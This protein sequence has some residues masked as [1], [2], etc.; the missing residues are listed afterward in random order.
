MQLSINE[1]LSLSRFNDSFSSYMHKFLF[2]GMNYVYEVC[3]STILSYEKINLGLL[4]YRPKSIIC[5]VFGF[6][7]QI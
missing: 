3:N 4:N 7:I 1:K 6:A 5:V 2:F